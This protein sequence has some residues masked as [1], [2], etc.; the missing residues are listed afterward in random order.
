MNIFE[1]ELFPYLDGEWV[2][3]TNP[4]LTIKSAGF[5]DITNGNRTDRKLVIHFSDSQKAMVTNKTNAKMIGRLYGGYTENWV[6]KRIALTTEVITAFGKTTNAIR[7]V[8]IVPPDPI[9]TEKTRFYQYVNARAEVQ[10]ENEAALLAAIKEKAPKFEWSA[11]A[12]IAKNGETGAKK[13]YAIAMEISEAKT[14]PDPVA[15]IYAEDLVQL[16]DTLNTGGNSK[17][18]TLFAMEMQSNGDAI[19]N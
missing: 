15:T 19:D 12:T 7:V 11:L 5:E 3:E 18:D 1:S 16:A 6:G 9:P 8:D 14:H 17:M 4:T 2:K 10:F 13:A